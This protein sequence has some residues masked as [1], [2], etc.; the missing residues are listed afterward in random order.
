MTAD[1][2]ELAT[3][4]RRELHRIPG[5]AFDVGEAADFVARTCTDLG[6]DVTTRV[7]GSGVVASLTRGTSTRSIA[8]RADMDGLPIDE[9]TGVAHSSH[10]HG[11]MHA[12]GHDGHMAMVLGAAAVLTEHVEFGGT[13]RLIF[14]P[15]EEPGTGAEAMIAD[16]LFARF[17]VDEVYGLHNMPGLPEGEIHTRS[18]PLMA[19]EDN[20]EIVVTGRGGHAS[21]PHLV[22]DPLVVAAEIILALQTI[23]ARS[24]DPLD[25]VVVSCTDLV[26]DGARNALPDRVVIRGDARTFHDADSALVEVRIREIAEGIARAH[27]AASEV[28]YTRVF[29]PTVNDPDCARHATAAAETAVGADRVDASCRAITASEDFAAFARAVP[30]CFAFLGA[31]EIADGGTAPLHSRRFDVN[32]AILPAGIDYYTAL[33][34]A[35][36]TE[37]NRA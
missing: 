26:T 27:R 37:E 35:R 17:P 29:R 25:A 1:P 7:G 21:A 11:A 14:Q 28:S 36:L 5:I 20:F 12:C 16:G 22:I 8:L 2:Y 15:A 33:V 4:W 19:A 13:V 10:T 24:V 23:V 32:D 30:A 18:G 31:G 6:W 34:R 9:R 3:R